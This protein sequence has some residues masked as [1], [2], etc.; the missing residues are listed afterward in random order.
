MRPEERLKNAR[1]KTIGTKQT[2]KAVQKG[3]ARMV[4]VAKD[5]ETRVIDPLIKL[6]TEKAVEVV[7]VP[8]MT[9]LGRACG[10]EVGSAS[11]AILD[12]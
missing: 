11:A 8:S 1:K 4:F 5:A 2:T 9:E 12:E 7:T 10:I 3:T 6:C